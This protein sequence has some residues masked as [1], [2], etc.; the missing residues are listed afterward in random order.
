MRSC[1]IN[2]YRTLLLSKYDN[3]DLDLVLSLAKHD[4][5]DAPHA[6]KIFMFLW[7]IATNDLVYGRVAAISLLVI[8]KRFYNN[9]STRVSVFV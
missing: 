8:V 3:F 4:N 5:L 1:L 9:V 6:S 2:G 7:K